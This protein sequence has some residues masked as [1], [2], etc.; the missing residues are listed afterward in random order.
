MT[1]FDSGQ[2]GYSQAM[3]DLQDLMTKA[4]SD[5]QAM[6][7]GAARFY[8]QYIVPD[9]TAAEAQIERMEN[10]GR[11][12]VSFSAAQFHAG[13]TIGDFGDLW[14]SPTTGF[15]HAELGE[16]VLSR[17][18]TLT[19]ASGS[20]SLAQLA[21]YLQPSAPRLTGTSSSG[22]SVAITIQAWDGASVD[23]WLRSGGAQKLQAALNS[24]IASYSGVALG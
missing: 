18:E 9:I 2:L 22:S 11:G 24:N 3:K 5:T 6:G 13:G 15:I 17:A 16:H 19:H 1:G 14:T 20:A 7:S 12:A 23:R 4:Q 8:R 10:V 21:S